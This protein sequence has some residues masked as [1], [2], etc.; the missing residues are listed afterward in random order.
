MKKEGYI[1]VAIMLIGASFLLYALSVSPA[2]SPCEGN[3]CS[4][5]PVENESPVQLFAEINGYKLSLSDYNKQVDMLLFVNGVDES[6]KS[7]VPP[8]Y[9]ID[10]ILVYQDAISHGYS[11]NMSK[12]ETYMEESIS[13]MGK[14]RTSFEKSIENKSF[15][16][17]D[18]LNFFAREFTINKYLN[19]VVLA[20]VSVSEM[21]ARAYYEANK[22]SF[23]SNNITLPYDT[24]KESIKNYLLDEKRK[25]VLE[26]YM[27][28]LKKRSNVEI[29]EESTAFEKRKVPTVELFVMSYCPYGTQME[30]AIIPVIEALGDNVNFSVKFC[31]YA[32]HGKKEIDENTRQYCIQKEEKENFLPYLRC[33]L[34]AGDS[35]AC[36]SRL[37]INETEI[38]DCMAEAD[39]EFDINK[40]YENRSSWLSGRYPVY[41]VYEEDVKKYAVR[42]SPTLIINGK[43]ISAE[44]SPSALLRLICSAFEEKPE[45]CTASLSSTVP[46]PGFGF[47][48]SGASSGGCGA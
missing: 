16:Y 10:R 23:I 24:V 44:R 28:N 21:E 43:E 19:E 29:F 3:S 15:G 4:V 13:R 18:L 6:Y 7:Q 47:E 26:Q 48:G 9:I 36:I 34:E 25:L 39:A 20:N 12:A 33:F 8:D 41:K 46:S 14:N 27:T 31:D 35:E 2:S 17:E 42:G 11:M 22:G 45:A 1:A 37:G 38:N 30:K 5:N 32:M 40:N